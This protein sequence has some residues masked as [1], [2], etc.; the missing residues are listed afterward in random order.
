M[1]EK[2]D[3]CVQEHNIMPISDTLKAALKKDLGDFI[4]TIDNLESQLYKAQ[5]TIYGFLSSD[6]RPDLA[7]RITRSV[8]R[9]A[10]NSIAKRSTRTYR[11][12]KDSEKKKEKVNKNSIKNNESN[13]NSSKIRVPVHDLQGLILRLTDDFACTQEGREIEGVY[14]RFDEELVD[15]IKQIKLTENIMLKHY[16]LSLVSSERSPAF[17]LTAKSS[18]VFDLDQID[19]LLLEEI[20]L[21]KK[22]IIPQRK[23]E[24]DLSLIRQHKHVIKEELIKRFDG[25]IK[26]IKQEKDGQTEEEIVRKINN[27]CIPC[28]DNLYKLA[29]PWDTECENIENLIAKQNN[30]SLVISKI[31]EKVKPAL[32]KIF[33]E[34]FILILT[35]SLI[36]NIRKQHELHTIYCCKDYKLLCDRANIK[37]TVNLYTPEWNLL[38]NMETNNENSSSIPNEIIETGDYGD[39]EVRNEIEAIKKLKIKRVLLLAGN[40]VFETIDVDQRKPKKFYLNNLPFITR[41]ICKNDN[42][43]PF[44]L[45]TLFADQIRSEP[46]W[47]KIFGMF[48]VNEIANGDTVKFKVGYSFL[49]KCYY[50]EFNYYHPEA[51]EALKP[52]FSPEFKWALGTLIVIGVCLGLFPRFYYGDIPEYKPTQQIIVNQKTPTPNPSPNFITPT[53]TSSPSVPEQNQ[54]AQEDRRP[55]EDKDKPQ[56]EP[57]VVKN[58]EDK[59]TQSNNNGIKHMSPSEK[60]DLTIKEIKKICIRQDGNKDYEKELINILSNSLNT[61]ELEYVADPKSADA[62]LRLTWKDIDRKQIVRLQ[63]INQVGNEILDAKDFI[64]DKDINTLA[65]RIVQYIIENK[66]AAK[67]HKLNKFLK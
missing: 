57:K 66:K 61:E 37:K 55:I 32:V 50:L 64:N 6:Y 5:E 45:A 56:K 35:P 9:E 16:I 23:I 51:L 28:V 24:T 15:S 18:L 40:E 41:V 3:F 58:D 21:E 62:Q 60:D 22:K 44:L 1:S 27:A 19:I 49:K 14:F 10:I 33:G 65:E 42:T 47:D 13:K 4:D 48:F 34:K 30:V 26:T 46:A 67:D 54:Q 38:N 59:Q 29:I 43:K 52:T 53:P 7:K 39:L 31:F 20:I 12:K 63:L 17:L 36:E 11:I 25:L 2:N 8:I